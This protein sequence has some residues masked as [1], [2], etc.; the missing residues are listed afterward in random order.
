M[1]QNV[2]VSFSCDPE[3]IHI[4]SDTFYI[5]S[6]SIYYNSLGIVI[7]DIII[8]GDYNSR[9]FVILVGQFIHYNLQGIVIGLPI[10]AS[11]FVRNCNH[12]QL[13]VQQLQLTYMGLPQKI[14]RI[15]TRKLLPISC[16]SHICT[17]ISAVRQE[18]QSTILRQKAIVRDEFLP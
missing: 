12:L 13:C 5:G 2:S 18:L 8:T 1:K 10:H 4:F 9:G 11:Q 17:K 6:T 14:E 3:R 15:S 7:T 16:D